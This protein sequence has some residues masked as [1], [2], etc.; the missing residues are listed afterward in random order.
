MKNKLSYI[1]PLLGICVLLCCCNSVNDEVEKTDYRKRFLGTWNIYMSGTWTDGKKVIAREYEWTLQIDPD[2]TNETKME[3][4]GLFA[5]GETEVFLDT[6]G[7]GQPYC[8]FPYTSNS[9]YE[10]GN[11][12]TMITIHE[13]AKIVNGKLKWAAWNT[14]K[15]SNGNS[16]SGTFKYIG[17]KVK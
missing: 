16:V 14:M 6:K 11:L 15:S 2:N 3:V 13:P 4:F 9:S 1:F 17:T 5:R 10:N 8:I 7:D 12:I